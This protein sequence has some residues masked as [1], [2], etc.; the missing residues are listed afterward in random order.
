MVGTVCVGG[1][2]LASMCMGFKNTAHLFW[3]VVHAAACNWRDG[4]AALPPTTWHLLLLQGC[5]AA[6]VF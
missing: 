1:W 3:I 4:Q 2:V 6:L 5:A